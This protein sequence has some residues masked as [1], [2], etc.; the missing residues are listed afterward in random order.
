MRW[1]YNID[2]YCDDEITSYV[3]AFHLHMSSLCRSHWVGKHDV[4][5]P[6]IFIFLLSSFYHHVHASRCYPIIL[7]IHLVITGRDS[8]LQVRCSS[9][10]PT[11]SSTNSSN[12]ST[13][14]STTNSTTN[15]TNNSTNNSTSCPGFL[16]PRAPTLVGGPWTCNTCKRTLGA[17]AVQVLLDLLSLGWCIW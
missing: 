6:I 1:N 10:S 15:S 17:S 5:G 12:S 11:N 4:S 3:Q 9:C 16:L 13:N 14:N 2:N 7:I 8:N